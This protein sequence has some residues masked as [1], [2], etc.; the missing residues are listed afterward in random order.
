MVSKAS[1]D[2]PEPDKP[3]MTTSLSRG[4]AT[5]MFLRLCSRA[6]RTWI[7]GPA[8]SKGIGLLIRGRGSAIADRDS[9]GKASCRIEC[10]NLLQYGIPH[11]EKRG[12]FREQSDAR[13][14]TLGPAYRD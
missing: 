2:F 10:I 13:G 5:S 12:S 9:S 6:P 14:E 7:F 1:E 8:T 11:L 3:V 4:S